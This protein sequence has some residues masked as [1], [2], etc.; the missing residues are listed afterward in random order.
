MSNFRNAETNALFEA[1]LSL[2]STQELSDFFEDVCTI[3][4]V[5]EMAQRFQVARLLHSGRNYQE[6]NT[7]TG[8]STA[9]IC[10]V[11][12]CLNYGTGGYLTAINRIKKEGQ[13]S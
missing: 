8:V 1:I 9:T 5:K 3:K 6:V 11:N 10:R 2:K 12:K 7:Q 13:N 4:E